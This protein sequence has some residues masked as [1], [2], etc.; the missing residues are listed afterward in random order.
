[1]TWTYTNDP[2][3][4]QLDELRL[5]IGDIDSA[6]PQL[7]DEELNYLLSSEGSVRPA[8]ME[9]VRL[10]LAY[11]AR[12]VDKSVGDL[13]LSY[14]QRK[15]QYEGLLAQLQY[16]TALRTAGP[17]IGGISK[18]RKETVDANPDRVAPA[19]RRDQFDH[20]GATHEDDLLSDD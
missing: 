16:Q 3:S 17:L 6:D 13:R 18:G 4:V 11:Y 15:D 14:S 20:P 7:T 8:A 1:M 9:A 19:F 10:L 2:S 5:L 12:L